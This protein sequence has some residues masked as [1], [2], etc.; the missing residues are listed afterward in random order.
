MAQ[1][2]DPKTGVAT[3]ASTFDDIIEAIGVRGDAATQGVVYGK[4][5]ALATTDAGG[6]NISTNTGWAIVNGKLYR[7]TAAVSTAVAAPSAG[8]TRIDRLV[9]RI[10]YTAS[11]ET[12]ALTLIGGVEDGAAPAVTQVDGTTWDLPLYQ[13]QVADGGGIT[14][15]DERAYLGDGHVRTASLAADCVT[16]AKIAD[17]QID[18]EHYV[19]G[20]ID[21]AHIGD[22]QVTAAKIAN[23]T[24]LLW[25]PTQ[26]TN[27]NETDSL[28]VTRQHAWPYGNPLTDG[29]IVHAWGS[30]TVPSDYVSDGV[31]VPVVYAAGT[32]NMYAG[33]SLYYAATGETPTEIATALAAQAMTNTKLTACTTI[34]TA[35]GAIAAGDFVSIKFY[36]DAV[37]ATDTIGGYCQ[38]MGWYL[39]Y[40]ADS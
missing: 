31:V 4:L 37:S 12:G 19:D 39:T 14:L 29:K 10:D 30:F 3:T 8:H 22:S 7:N 1:S 5:N 2:I 21:T 25:I 11:P 32:G 33:Q 40:T 18:S 36:R 28:P 16:S 13:V 15:V 20:S 35:F 26:D 38:I 34:Q 17:D 6:G 23:R 9:V 27:W 24:R